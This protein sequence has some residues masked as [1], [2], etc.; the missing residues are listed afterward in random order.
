[1]Q[2]P[3]SPTMFTTLSGS[4]PKRDSALRA[5]RPLSSR[6]LGSIDLRGTQRW[7]V[8]VPPD[9]WHGSGGPLAPVS[10]CE[11][12]LSGSECVERHR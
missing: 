5:R 10:C 6:V 11:R 4:M 1:M 12:V 7:T 2:L 9:A 3:Y 8:A